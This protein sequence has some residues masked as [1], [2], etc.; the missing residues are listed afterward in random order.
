MGQVTMGRGQSSGQ[1]AQSLVVSGRS[2]VSHTLLPHTTATTGS[3][4][5]LVTVTREEGEE[6]A[7][8]SRVLMSAAV[9]L[10]GPP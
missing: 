2:P 5:T 4:T 1:P 3:P 8:V 7:V 6:G 9:R 10:L